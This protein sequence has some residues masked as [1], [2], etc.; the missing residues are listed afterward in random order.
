MREEY[1]QRLAKEYRF[2]A[3]RMK[4]SSQIPQKLFYFS[5]LFGEAQR[6][7]NFEWDADLVLIQMITQHVHT[8]FAGMTQNPVPLQGLPIDWT[9][10]HEK[11]TQVASDLAT[12]FEKKG[13]DNSKEELWQILCRLAEIAFAVSGNG[14]YLRERGMFKL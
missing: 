5:V 11:L 3:I 2:A 6:V 8:Q 9:M 4:E 12:Y 1:K 14:S 7:L 13:N 10:L